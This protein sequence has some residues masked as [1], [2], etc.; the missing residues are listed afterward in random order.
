MAHAKFPVE[1]LTPE[2]EVFNDEVEMVS[3]R[4][5]VG[6]IGVLANMSPVLAMLEPTELRLYKSDSEIV[7]YAQ[8]E[9]YMQVAGNRVLLLVEEVHAP[10]SLDAPALR[11]RLS[12]AEQDLDSAGDD[13][14][15]RR[16]AQ[17]DKTRWE[18]FLKV[19]EG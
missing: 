10:E 5:T 4:T 8:S 18:A 9:G 7:R 3:T 16:M 15:K 17:R 14:E 1:L 11:D 12:Q 2:G 19:A 13:T 6:Q